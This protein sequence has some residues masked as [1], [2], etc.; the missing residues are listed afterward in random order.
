MAYVD[1]IRRANDRVGLLP[2]DRELKLRAGLTDGTGRFQVELQG[3]A[4]AGTYGTKF[5]MAGL[6][7]KPA[8]ECAVNLSFG[9]VTKVGGLWVG[10]EK[11]STVQEFRLGPQGLALVRDYIKDRREKSCFFV[12]EPIYPFQYLSLPA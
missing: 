9:R 6:I 3:D 11:G 7:G 12:S 1:E 4:R 5:V 10:R 2:E 8:L